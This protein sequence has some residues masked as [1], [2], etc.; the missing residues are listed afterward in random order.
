MTKNQKRY[1]NPPLADGA[2]NQKLFH[3]KEN[4]LYK[5]YTAHRTKE[6]IMKA[7]IKEQ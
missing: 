1:L 5:K 3:R 4:G 2:S 6:I 7:Y